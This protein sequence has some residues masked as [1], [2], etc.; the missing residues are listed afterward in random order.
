MP[1]QVYLDHNATTPLEPRVLAEMLPYLEEGFGNPSSG[2]AF[3]AA[4]AAA[5]AAARERAAALLGCRPAEVTFT[6]GGTESNN[7]A[8]VGAVAARGGGGH[9]VTT[10][11]E[12]PSVLAVCRHLERR[13]DCSVTYL[14][15]DGDGRVDPDDVARAVT[16]A[17]VAVSIM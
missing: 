4:A 15:V 8:L 17:T 9:L 12:H 3:G 5:V 13:W 10:V 11:V 16:P 6:G 7:L 14:P 1:T 2:H